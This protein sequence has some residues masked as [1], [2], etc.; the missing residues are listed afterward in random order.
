MS[1]SIIHCSAMH[2]DYAPH[3]SCRELNRPSSLWS[4]VFQGHLGQPQLCLAASCHTAVVAAAAAAGPDGSDGQAL[5]GRAGLQARGG[6]P[7]PPGHRSR[8]SSR[9]SISADPK[10][11]K[12][13]PEDGAGGGSSVASKAGAPTQ[14]AGTSAAPS[15]GVELY[16][17]NQR[18]ELPPK[19]Q[20]QTQPQQQQLQPGLPPSPLQQQPQQSAPQPP[21]PQQPLQQ[22]QA[23]Q[24]QWRPPPTP[25]PW[26]SR[27]KAAADITNSQGPSGNGVHQLDNSS[28]S[29]STSNDTSTSISSSSSRGAPV[30]PPPAVQEAPLEPHLV[31]QGGDGVLVHSLVAPSQPVSEEAFDWVA[32]LDLQVDNWGEVLEEWRAGMATATHPFT[33]QQVSKRV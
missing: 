20:Q 9:V 3:A 26:D 24:Q 6:P 13:P 15:L 25:A 7:R 12:P 5:Q 32:S 16:K 4:A 29:S 28:S 30:P 21:L 23:W 1:M 8:R 10:D 27:P 11:S 22:Q 19:V 31:Q 2:D 14:D 17:Q 18:V 33:K